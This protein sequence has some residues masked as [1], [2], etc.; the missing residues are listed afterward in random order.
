MSEEGGGLGVDDAPRTFV[1]DTNVLLFD[2]Q[3]LFAFAEHDVVIPMTVIEEVDRFKKDAN[4]TGRNARETSRHLDALRSEG[5]LKRGVRLP[6]GGLL[7][8]D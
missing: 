1:V 7:R 5:S 2:S 6:G 3:A 4:E 8:V